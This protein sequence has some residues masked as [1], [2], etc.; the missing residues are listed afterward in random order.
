[1]TGSEYGFLTG[2][3]AGSTGGVEAAGAFTA[4]VLRSTSVPSGRA[5]LIALDVRGVKDAAP[6]DIEKDEPGVKEEAFGVKT[7][8]GCIGREGVEGNPL[9]I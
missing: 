2:V 5:I 1:M 6:L 8:V 4:T 9:G 7:G 3:A